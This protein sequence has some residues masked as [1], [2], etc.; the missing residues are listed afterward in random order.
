MILPPNKIWKTDKSDVLGSLSHTFNL[1]LTE[2]FGKTKVSPR[3]IIT[4]NGIS[5]FGTPVSFREHGGNLY[6]LAP[7]SISSSNGLFVASG[8]L[9]KTPFVASTATGVNDTTF[10]SN[11]SD[12][13]V[14]FGRIVITGDSTQFLYLEGIDFIASSAVLTANTNHKLLK[15]TT[16]NLCYVFGSRFKVFSI[17]TDLSANTSGEF[18]LNLE[19]ITPIAHG[20]FLISMVEHEGFI[21]ILTGDI[22]EGSAYIFKWDG[23]T[24]NVFQ[25]YYPIYSRA[26]LAGIVADG[27]LYIMD[28]DGQLRYFNGA[29]FVPAPNGKLPIKNHSYLTNPLSLKNDR[30][31]H[32][33]GIML[34]N[35]RINILINNLNNDNGGTVEE[36]IASGIWEYDPEIGWYHKNSLSQY[37]YSAGSPA[38]ID[39]GQNRLSRVGALVNLNKDDTTATTVGTYMAGADYYTTATV[40]KSASWTNDSL[41]LLQK[42][43]YFVTSRIFGSHFDEFWRNLVIRLQKLLSATDK[44]VVKYRS[45]FTPPTEATITWVSAT[46][47][48]TTTDVSAY[49]A[50]NG[51]DEVEIIQG[52]GSGKC[53]HIASISVNM[54]TYTVTL[55]ETYPSGVSGTAKARF[56]HWTKLG[57]FSDQQLPFAKFAG[58]N[59]S[60]WVQLKVCMLFTG[61]NEI[62]DLLIDNTP[63]Q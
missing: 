32:P 14:F 17:N 11:Y 9:L 21:W 58:M 18:T 42:Y 20:M 27:A 49:T 33:N 52:S 59:N 12:M 25:S 44:I 38:V 7:T 46:S 22:Y 30:W 37:D 6:A 35:G 4:T 39:Y 26:A 51:G 34:D 36:R 19:N 8:G 1:N 23:V 31:L 57:S 47:F 54:G 61:N 63:R 40:T 5:N 13:E 41:D 48:T 53:A 56:Q 3:T 43:G 55:D 2:D 24:E 62:Y 15:S 50:A 29:A 45:N 28:A 10:S 60:P 16:N